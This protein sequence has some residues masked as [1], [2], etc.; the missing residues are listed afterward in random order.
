MLGANKVQGGPKSFLLWK[1]GAFFQKKILTV[2]EKLSLIEQSNSI[3]YN[4]FFYNDAKG[5][6]TISQDKISKYDIASFYKL[7]LNIV[8]I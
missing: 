7:N 2:E 4:I 8:L 5:E 3:W 6:Y 1:F